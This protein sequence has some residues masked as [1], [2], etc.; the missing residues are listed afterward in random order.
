ML[1]AI[2]AGAEIDPGVERARL[3]A[4][5]LEPS[6]EEINDPKQRVLRMLM[7]A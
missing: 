2:A 4:A 6:A 7:E 3:D 5:L 1:A